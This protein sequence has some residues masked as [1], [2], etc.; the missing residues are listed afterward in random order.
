MKTPVL[1]LNTST[2]Q[3][4]IDTGTIIRIEALSNYCKLYFANGKTLVTAKLLKWFEEK[5]SPQSFVRM[6]RSHLIN[7]HF[8]QP[9]QCIDKGFVLLNGECIQVSRRKRKMILHQ[10]QVA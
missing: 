3:H 6:H 1:L 5:L 7:N 10:L 9:N 8:L 2:G 4:L